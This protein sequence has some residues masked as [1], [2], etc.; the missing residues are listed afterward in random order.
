[1]VPITPSTTSVKKFCGTKK[2]TKAWVEPFHASFVWCGKTER[3]MQG[4]GAASP[5]NSSFYLEKQL[6]LHTEACKKDCCVVFGAG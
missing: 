5:T 6:F 3:G 1:M 4:H 2:A